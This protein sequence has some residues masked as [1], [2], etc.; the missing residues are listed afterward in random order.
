MSFWSQTRGQFLNYCEQQQ[1]DKKETLPF[2]EKNKMSFFKDYAPSY[3]AFTPGGLESIAPLLLGG[4]PTGQHQLF[5]LKGIRVVA[6][7]Q[8]LSQLTGNFFGSKRKY[9]GNYRIDF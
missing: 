8:K 1:L 2:P 7:F 9:F 5:C 6:W 3:M 4:P